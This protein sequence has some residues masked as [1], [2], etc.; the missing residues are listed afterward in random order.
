MGLFTN[1]IERSDGSKRPDDFAYSNAIFDMR[2]TLEPIAH[3][4]MDTVRIEAKFSTMY[5]YPV[6]TKDSDN[7]KRHARSAA[8]LDLADFAYRDVHIH[9]SGIEQ[10]LY[11][12]NRNKAFEALWAL[13]EGLKP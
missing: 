8:L 1:L 5:A 9:L 6:F 13:R 4:H 10:A 11:A 3:S 2:E 7:I 12:G